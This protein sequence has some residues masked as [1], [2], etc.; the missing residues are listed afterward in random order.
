MEIG[1]L[2]IVRSTAGRD[3]GQ[4]FVVIA[5]E[6]EYLMLVNGATRRLERPKRKKR[7]HVAIVETSVLRD[8]LG[9]S[10][11]KAITNGDLRKILALLRA[12]HPDQEG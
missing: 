1:R 7:K 3:A 9:G 12:D 2:D 10:E 6:G 11:G 5:A 4:Y 8:Y